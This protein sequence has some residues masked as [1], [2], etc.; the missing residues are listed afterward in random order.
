M[1]GFVARV[2]VRSC[3][4]SD[5][6]ALAR[7]RLDGRSPLAANPSSALRF[8]RQAVGQSNRVACLGS[9]CSTIEPEPMSKIFSF[10]DCRLLTRLYSHLLRMVP[11]S[12]VGF[13]ADGSKI[14]QS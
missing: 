9:R 1:R 4:G 2:G 7:S 8:F 10:Q 6:P 3:T 5:R 11:P 13:H 14:R 12:F